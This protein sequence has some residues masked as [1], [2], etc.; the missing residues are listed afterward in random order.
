M[1]Q[2]HAA[3]ARHKDLLKPSGV[4]VMG[5]EETSRSDENEL[6]TI[7]SSTGGVQQQNNED[8]LL[9]KEQKVR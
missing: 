6:N 1:A 2:Q 4:K 8:D 5:R 3:A 9:P 7:A